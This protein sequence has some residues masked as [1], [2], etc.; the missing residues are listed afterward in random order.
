MTRWYEWLL[1]VAGIPVVLFLLIKLLEHLNP[2]GQSLW[3]YKG[4]RMKRKHVMDQL[5]YE[6]S[7]L[8][9][10]GFEP[11]EVFG[12]MKCG[13]PTYGTVDKGKHTKYCSVCANQS[14]ER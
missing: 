12:C 4:D 13:R 5:T 8:E 7:R 9:H 2:R 3:H 10:S 1:A 14:P 11:A 6:R